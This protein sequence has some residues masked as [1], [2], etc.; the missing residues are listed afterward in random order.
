MWFASCA[1]RQP[2]WNAQAIEATLVSVNHEPSLEDWYLERLE[3]RPKSQLCQPISTDVE[4]FTKI[5]SMWIGLTYDL[6]NTLDADY[7]L[8][9]PGGASL[10]AME[11]LR[12]AHRVLITAQTLIWGPI[13]PL[14]TV[15]SPAPILIPGR[16]TVRVL[17]EIEY[18]MFDTD[19]P[20]FR[21]TDW[22]ESAQESF[23]RQQ[24]AGV[25]EFVLFDKT[26]RYRIE[27]QVRR[28]APPIVTTR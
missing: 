27:L 3:K 20:C 5:G 25:E 12:Q 7:V 14:R 15:A 8:T 13:K 1:S 18:E 9:A 10:V 2:A 16:K 26:S 11:E 17:F 28:N 19:F 23:V 4:G 24:F 6:Q 22:T 21:R